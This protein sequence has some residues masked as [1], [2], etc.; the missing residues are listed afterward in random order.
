MYHSYD[1]TVCLNLKEAFVC[2]K[3]HMCMQQQLLHRVALLAAAR[4]SYDNHAF[5]VLLNKILHNLQHEATDIVFTML[6][7]IPSYLLF[8]SRVEYIQ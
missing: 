8:L 5:S 6:F 4:V 3:K 1:V 2:T 7:A